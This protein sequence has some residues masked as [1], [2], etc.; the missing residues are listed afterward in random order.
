MVD[1]SEEVDGLNPL[2]AKGDKARTPTSG[3]MDGASAS[4]FAIVEKVHYD[5]NLGRRLYAP[6]TTS[7]FS[8]CSKVDGSRMAI[9]LQGHVSTDSLATNIS[10][11]GL[12]A[13][14]FG[15]KN[16]LDA[17][18]DMSSKM[19][20]KDKSTNVLE[21]GSGLGRSMIIADMMKICGNTG[22]CVLTDGEEEVM[23]LLRSNVVTNGRDED[24]LTQ[25][26]RWGD[27]G[28]MDSVL[29]TCPNGF[30][31]II[32][33]DAIYG[34]QAAENLD[35]LMVTVLQLLASNEMSV[36]YLA[37][38]RR[39][40]IGVESVQEVASKCGLS[41]ETMDDYTYDIFANNVDT[42]SDFWSD[43]I[44]RMQRMKS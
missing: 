31:V 1:M 39:G 24:I 41:C 10:N 8:L 23:E 2:I 14:W 35:N 34:P 43:T 25:L 6:T 30:E 17:V 44:L 42:E 22:V 15:G 19:F 21:L 33:A 40:T 27:A 38:A 5:K 7:S 16:M 9:E 20:A 18:N 26:L 36:F 11:T 29:A 37:L 13:Q 3:T 12:T 32:A 28:H 4:D